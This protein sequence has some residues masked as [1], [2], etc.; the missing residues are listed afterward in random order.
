MPD[1]QRPGTAPSQPISI[2]DVS[3]TSLLRLARASR[4]AAKKKLRGLSSQQQAHACVE[5]RPESRSEF[6]LLLDHPERVVPLLPDSEVCLTVRGAGMTDGAW[7]LELSTPEQRRACYDLDCWKATR[8]EPDRFAEWN[9]AL[10]EAGPETLAEAVR[11]SDL[12]LWILWLRAQVD[13]VIT[14]KEDT[15]PIG[16]ISVD[17]VVHLVPHEGVDPAPVEQLARTLAG[18]SGRE[19]WQLVY[20]VMFE[21]PSAMEED[22]LRWRNSR[23]TDLGF[24]DREQA[25][26]IYARL[27]PDA[28]PERAAHPSGPGLVAATR[29]PRQLQYTLVGEALQKLPPDRAADVLGYVLA[30]ANAV[31][32]ADDA[33]LSDSESLP[34]AL[35][36]A[37]RGID[38]GLREL[39]RARGQPLEQVLD[40]TVPVDLFRIGATVEPS[41]RKPWVPPD[42]EEDE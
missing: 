25:L 39:S 38:A 12:E 8:F 22:A 21:S 9:E 23:L 31:A 2:S 10:I 26:E 34:R 24:P 6:L 11:E 1:E 27:R 30:V 29:L 42:D 18:E 36:K 33:V 7:L 16:A 37:V 19:Y 15:P 17:G 32:V 5:L 41:L 4:D 14:G 20:G 35:E 28:V 40:R 3:G 13:L